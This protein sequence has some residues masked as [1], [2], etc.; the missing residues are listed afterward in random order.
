MSESVTG[1]GE[2]VGM[3]GGW[4][5]GSLNQMSLLSLLHLASTHARQGWR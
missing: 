1:E 4:G 3:G 2:E 5:G